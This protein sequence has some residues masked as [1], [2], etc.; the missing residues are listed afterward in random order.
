MFARKKNNNDYTLN[1]YCPNCNCNCGID[2]Q[3]ETNI[4]ISDTKTNFIL[5]SSIP[6]QKSSTSPLIFFDEN[7]SNIFKT[8]EQ[9][10]TKLKY[11]E[12]REIEFKKGIENFKIK[13]ETLNQELQNIRDELE[14]KHNELQ[15]KQN[16]LDNK[17]I[18]LKLAES[19]LNKKLSDIEYIELKK[20]YN[21]IGLNK[22]YNDTDLKYYSSNYLDELCGKIK[23]N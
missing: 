13:S 20:E 23:K 21:L 17:I 12:Q 11:L 7:K 8:N 6:I 18:K 2:I 5:N 9:I 10:E 1:I 16:E 22:E 3:V 15:Q 14:N 19:L 4:K